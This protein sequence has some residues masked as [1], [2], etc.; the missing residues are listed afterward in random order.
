LSGDREGT[1]LW[2]FLEIGDRFR[3]AQARGHRHL[4][5]RHTLDEALGRKDVAPVAALYAS[6]AALESPSVCHLMG[7]ERAILQ[8]REEIR[9]FAARVFEG[10][11]P[12]RRQY[13]QSTSPTAK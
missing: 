13:R 12:L 4:G 1:G 5:S 9:R 3:R 11:T 2:Q 7:L 6:D 10:Q 8:R